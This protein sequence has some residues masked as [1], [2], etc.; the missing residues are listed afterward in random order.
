MQHFRCFSF[1]LCCFVFSYRCHLVFHVFFLRL[2][3]SMQISCFLF[4][5]GI[6]CLRSSGKGA[7]FR[8][9]RG[10][11]SI[12]GG[13]FPF[14]FLSSSFRALDFVISYLSLFAYAFTMGF[15]RLFLSY[16]SFQFSSHCRFELSCLYL[17]CCFNDTF[18]SFVSISSHCVRFV[19]FHSCFPGSGF[20]IS[21]LSV[22]PAC[23][24]LVV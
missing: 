4:F 5:S 12:P 14:H 22:F 8:D 13:D 23:R 19:R 9:G 24:F 16:C 3:L 7:P 6:K 18:L 15:S 11:G 20:L 1:D 17:L 10:P 21:N 2:V